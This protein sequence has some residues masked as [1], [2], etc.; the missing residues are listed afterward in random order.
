LSSYLA[1]FPV[2][3][4]YF[5]FLINEISPLSFHPVLRLV[6]DPLLFERFPEIAVNARHADTANDEYAIKKAVYLRDNA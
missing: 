5:I 2:F 3:C 6:A 4:V 1:D